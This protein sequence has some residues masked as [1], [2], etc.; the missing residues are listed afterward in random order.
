MAASRIMGPILDLVMFLPTETGKMSVE[1]IVDCYTTSSTH[2][3]AC[4]EVMRVAFLG[5]HFVALTAFTDDEGHGDTN[6]SDEDPGD[7]VFG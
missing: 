4:V 5:V 1:W 6:H 7:G 2:V 3:D